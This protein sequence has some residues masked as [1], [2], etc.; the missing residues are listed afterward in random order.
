MD[1]VCETVSREATPSMVIRTRCSVTELPQVIGEAYQRIAAYLGSMNKEPAGPPYVGYH[2]EDMQDLDLEI[3]FPVSEEIQGEN[4][5]EAS[6][7][8]AGRYATTIHTG[9]YSKF[10]EAYSRLTAW[11]TT[12]SLHPLG[13]AYE[14][15]LNDPGDTLDEA[16]QTLILLPIA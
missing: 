13:S 7:I 10:E 1:A 3:G 16:L 8:P 12:Q 5:I 9:P 6:E 4:A 2:N 14:I 11:V 15:Y